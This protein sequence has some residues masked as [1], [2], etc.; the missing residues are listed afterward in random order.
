MPTDFQKS[1]TST[2]FALSPESSLKTQTQRKRVATLPCETRDTISTA[3]ADVLFSRATLYIHSA[4][5][6]DNQLYKRLTPN[7]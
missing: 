5:F 7:V 6:C 3:V 4:V 1:S 2:K